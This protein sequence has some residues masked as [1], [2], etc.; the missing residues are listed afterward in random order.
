MTEPLFTHVN[1]HLWSFFSLAENE[2]T[3][4]GPSRIN[5]FEDEHSIFDGTVHEKALRH[6]RFV[7][8][9]TYRPA[10]LFLRLRGNLSDGGFFHSFNPH[11]RSE[12]LE[13][14]PK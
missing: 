8:V 12:L 9:Q 1:P 7:R 6:V 10:R 11:V 2:F 13:E 5:S 3:I 14:A 4:V